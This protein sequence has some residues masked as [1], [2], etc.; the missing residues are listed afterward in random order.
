M[1]LQAGWIVVAAVAAAGALAAAGTAEA[2]AK[3]KASVPKIVIGAD[4][5]TAP[6]FSY[7]NAIRERVFIPVPGVDQDGDGITDNVAADIVRPAE[8]AQGMK[9]PAIIDASPYYTSIGRGNEGEFI[10]TSASGIADGMPLFYDN[11]FVPRGYAFIAAQAVGTAF[12]TGCP[13]HGGPG[14]GAGV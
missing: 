13:L 2:S 12:S 3:S 11:Y 6:A 7:A 8:T 4:G 14:D 1:K 5:E 9:V 10:H